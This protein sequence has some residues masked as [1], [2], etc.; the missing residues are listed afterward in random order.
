MFLFKISY[1]NNNNKFILAQKELAEKRIFLLKIGMKPPTQTQN[2]QLYGIVCE[3]F[4]SHGDQQQQQ[5]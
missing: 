4:N 1:N 5:Q 3:L 2:R